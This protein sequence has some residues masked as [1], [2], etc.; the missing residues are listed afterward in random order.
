[1]MLQ[2]LEVKEAAMTTFGV[3][4]SMGLDRGHFY[5]TVDGVRLNRQFASNAMALGFIAALKDAERD[6]FVNGV[7]ETKS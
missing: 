4:F 2:A 6:G 5:V 1:M 3:G 7:R